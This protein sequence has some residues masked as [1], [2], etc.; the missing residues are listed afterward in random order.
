MRTIPEPADEGPSRREFLHQAAAGAVVAGSVACPSPEEVAAAPQT[1]TPAAT[2]PVTLQVNGRKRELKLEPRVTL[3]D[4]LREYLGLT[5]EGERTPARR[6]DHRGRAAGPGLVPPLALPE[7]PRPGVL[8]V[9]PG[10]GGRGPGGPGRQGPVGPAGA[11][12]GG[13]QTLALCRGRE[14]PGRGQPWPRRLR[15]GGE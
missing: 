10:L 8:R 9:R 4:A 12:R 6:A 15:P 1:A 5:G 13:D 7:G 2:V 11:G 14:G 3:L